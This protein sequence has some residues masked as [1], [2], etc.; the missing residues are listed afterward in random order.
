MDGITVATCA[1]GVMVASCN[2]GAVAFPSDL[3]LETVLFGMF[4]LIKYFSFSA[5]IRIN[6][7]YI[8]FK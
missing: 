7:S 1:G 6:V 5:R 2:V 3:A 8:T 4:V